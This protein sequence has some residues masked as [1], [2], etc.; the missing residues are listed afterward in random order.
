SQSAFSWTR[1]DETRHAVPFDKLREFLLNDSAAAARGVAQDNT[2]TLAKDN[3]GVKDIQPLARR[4]EKDQIAIGQLAA[5]ARELALREV[6]KADNARAQACHGIHRLRFDHGLC[7]A[8]EVTEP[9]VP[10]VMPCPIG[11]IVVALLPLN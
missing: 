5:E 7:S 4:D 6:T 3:P 8:R 2:I 9:S 1:D 10:D 11:S